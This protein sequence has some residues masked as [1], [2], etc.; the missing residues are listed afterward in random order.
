MR[1]ATPC[2]FCVSRRHGGR[3]GGAGRVAR[4]DAPHAATA[5]TVG[6]AKLGL[7]SARRAAAAV[8]PKAAIAVVARP[9]RTRTQRPNGCARVTWDLGECAAGGG[10]GGEGRE[11]SEGRAL[12]V[13]APRAWRVL[14]R[15][16]RGSLHARGALALSHGVGGE[17]AASGAVG[18]GSGGGGAGSGRAS[19]TRDGRG[20]IGS[21]VRSARSAWQL[22]RAL[23]RSWLRMLGATQPSVAEPTAAVALATATLADCRGQE[24]LRRR[25]A[26]AR[27]QHHH[28]G[29]QGRAVAL[30]A[31]PVGADA[32]VR[33][34]RA[35]NEVPPQ[36]RLQVGTAWSNCSYPTSGLA[37]AS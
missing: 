1:S 37:H 36:R 33:A 14:Q 8:A 23:C 29:A 27:A 10:G 30:R 16:R 13:S 31:V 6:A 11:R 25:L 9:Q 18:R 5:E 20:R 26:G 28:G 22:A 32:L 24:S 4:A 35:H 7:V 17:Q 12:S 2:A 15:E 3:G 34:Q 19:H 21:D